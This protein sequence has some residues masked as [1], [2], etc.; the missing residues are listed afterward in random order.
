MCIRDRPLT[1]TIIGEPGSQDVQGLA[2][3][4]LTRMVHG[5]LVLRFRRGSSNEPAKAD[6]QV[7]GRPVASIADADQITQERIRHLAQSPGISC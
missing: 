3:A 7:D 5:D 1:V 6:F 4:A 2:K